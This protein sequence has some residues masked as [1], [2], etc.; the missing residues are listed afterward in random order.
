MAINVDQ[1]QTASG[2]AVW[3]GSS[4]CCFDK[5]HVNSGFD[6]QEFIWEQKEIEIL[7][8]LPYI[9]LHELWIKF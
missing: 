5:H 9:A 7:E 3:S 8:H 4:A 6:N 2:G 1:Y